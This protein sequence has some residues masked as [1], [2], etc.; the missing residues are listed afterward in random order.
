MLRFLGIDPQSSTVYAAGASPPSPGTLFQSTDG[1]TN[2]TS[3]GSFVIGFSAFAI[4]PQ[5]PRTLYVASAG[6]VMKSIDRGENWNDLPV[7]LDS[8]GGCDE[9]LAVSIL[10]IDPRDSS[11]VYACGS[12]GVL[13]SVDRGATWNAMNSGLPWAP[14]QSNAISSFVIDPDNSNNVYVAIAGR[15]FRSTDGAASWSEVNAGWTA[16]A[17][18]YLYGGRYLFGGHGSGLALDPTD[19]STLYVGTNGGGI[20]AITFV[21]ETNLNQMVDKRRKL[22][23]DGIRTRP[24]ASKPSGRTF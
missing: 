7:P 18:G 10:T 14:S 6:R 11:T 24:T 3:S 5:I 12:I 23:S 13:K 1:G 8:I 16:T 17:R 22:N 4:D 15:V 21:P 2:W 19:P 9:C 20:H